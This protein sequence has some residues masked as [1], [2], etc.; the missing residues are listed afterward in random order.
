MRLPVL[1]A[2]ECM[3]QTICDATS[4]R[5]HGSAWAERVGQGR[6]VGTPKWW[7]QHGC[8]WTWLWKFLGRA[9]SL[10][11]SPDVTEKHSCHITEHSTATATKLYSVA[12]DSYTNQVYMHISHW[13][14]AHTITKMQWC[15][16]KRTGLHVVHVQQT[17]KLIRKWKLRGSTL[18][19]VILPCRASMQCSRPIY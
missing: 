7:K 4:S 16:D 17:D 19:Q 2:I 6:W 9:I 15:M 3:H 5:L 11:L 13:C 12:N 14:R 18:P 1:N 8:V 10:I